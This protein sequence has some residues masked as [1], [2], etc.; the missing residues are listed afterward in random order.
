LENGTD[1]KGQAGGSGILSAII[2]WQL[3]WMSDC[4]YWY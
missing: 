3:V 1:G 4:L 2:G